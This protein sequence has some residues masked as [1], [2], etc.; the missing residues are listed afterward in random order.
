MTERS[1]STRTGIIAIASAFAIASGALPA[2]AQTIEPVRIGVLDLHAKDVVG[3]RTGTSVIYKEFVEQGSKSGRA[4]TPAG[5]DHGQ[6]VASAMLE[7]FRKLDRDHPVEIYAANAFSMKDKGDGT[8][9]LKFSFEQ[10]V[11]ALEWMSHN[12]VRVVVTAFNSKNEAGSRMLMDR[13]ESLG[14]VVFAGAPNTVGAGK[15]FPAAD[16][17][18]VSVLDSSP[19]MPMDKD[20]SLRTWVSFGMDGT[21]VAGSRENRSREVGSSYASAKAGA[22]GAYV[23]SR[24]PDASRE[25][26]VV[27]MSSAARTSAKHVGFRIIG[28][29]ES[30]RALTESVDA[31]LAS[32]RDPRSLVKGPVRQNAD[33]ASLDLAK[34]AMEHASSR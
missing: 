13:A 30:D 3:P 10:G 1:R 29:R 27:M 11:R 17:R 20:P 18:S 2:S 7:Q 26:V 28:E 34:T 32:A 33:L 6:I 21:Y 14:M 24:M 23:L 15:V 25:Q 12:G 16:P 22:Y 31:A 9:S 19:D 8:I 4:A 5:P